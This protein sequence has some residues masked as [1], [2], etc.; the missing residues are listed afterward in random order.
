MRKEDA[1]QVTVFLEQILAT[2]LVFPR[3]FDPTFLRLL[4]KGIGLGTRRHALRLKPRD[5]W[6]VVFVQGHE[7]PLRRDP[8][9]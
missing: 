4:L 7:I 1:S 3:P 9:P 5:R 8:V 6:R 2:D